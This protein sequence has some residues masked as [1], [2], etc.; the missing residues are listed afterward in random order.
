MTLSIAYIA[1]PYTSINYRAHLLSS[2]ICI[3]PLLAPEAKCYYNNKGKRDCYNHYNDLY[4]INQYRA[5]EAISASRG[6]DN[7]GLF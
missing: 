7:S 2:A 1:G 4:V 6:Q 5:T 3:K